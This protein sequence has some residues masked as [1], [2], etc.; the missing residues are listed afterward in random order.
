M[1]YLTLNAGVII[2][3]PPGRG[4]SILNK[5]TAAGTAEQNVIIRNIPGRGNFL[6]VA[7]RGGVTIPSTLEH[8][9]VSNGGCCDE[10]YEVQNPANI[11][12]SR[13]HNLFLSNCL[14]QNSEG[15]G[16]Y[17]HPYI[18]GVLNSEIIQIDCAFVNNAGDDICD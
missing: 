17:T 5:L 6:K 13:P 15:C 12:L 10:I 16:I 3:I 9:V 1:R 2:E 11:E 18:E 14:I 8:C 4:M 7:L